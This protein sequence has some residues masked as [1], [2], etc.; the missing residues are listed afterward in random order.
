MTNCQNMAADF[1]SRSGQGA[2]PGSESS[3]DGS[4]KEGTIFSVWEITQLF[5][6]WEL[7]G[8]NDIQCMGDY[9]PFHQ[10]SWRIL[11]EFGKR[12]EEWLCPGVE[13]GE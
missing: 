1:C 4:W 13:Q 8:G 9:T 6:G 10:T 11:L 12:G 3:M 7:E 2:L 5:H